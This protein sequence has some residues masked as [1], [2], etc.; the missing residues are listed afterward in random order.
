MV[1]K[2]K[3]TDLSLMKTCKILNDFF[4][5][6]REGREKDWREG[7]GRDCSEELEW[8]IGEKIGTREKNRKKNRREGKVEGIGEKGGERIGEKNRKKRLVRR[9]EK[10]WREGQEKG[11]SEKEKNKV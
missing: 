6:L 5:C 4:D 2:Q 3:L 11:I 1:E 8:G 7:R 9:R 10:N